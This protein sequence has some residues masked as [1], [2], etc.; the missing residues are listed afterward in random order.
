MQSLTDDQT[1]EP[2]IGERVQFIYIDSPTE[3]RTADRLDKHKKCPSL[4]VWGISNT[5]IKPAG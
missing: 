4:Y 3:E 5:L 1:N 2:S